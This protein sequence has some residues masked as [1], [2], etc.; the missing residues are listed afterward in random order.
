MSER[1]VCD[2]QRGTGWRAR[3]SNNRGSRSTARRLERDKVMQV[4]NLLRQTGDSYPVPFLQTYVICKYLH[5]TYAIYS[6]GKSQIS[7]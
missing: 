5:I 6:T 7:H 1:M 2:F 3:K 4:R